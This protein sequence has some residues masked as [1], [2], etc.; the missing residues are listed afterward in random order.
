MF[1]CLFLLIYF[2]GR[3]TGFSAGRGMGGFSFDLCIRL[4]LEDGTLSFQLAAVC[5][6]VCGEW[7]LMG[8]V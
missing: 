2:L 1:F 5:G 3:D 8:G 4:W 6:E 7:C